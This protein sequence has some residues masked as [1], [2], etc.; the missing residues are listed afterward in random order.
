M[1]TIRSF[2]KVDDAF[3]PVSKY[4][5]EFPDPEFIDGAIEIEFDG[6]LMLSCKDWDYIDQLWGYLINGLFTIAEGKKFNTCL[7]EQVTELSFQPSNDLKQIK[8]EVMSSEYHKV[9]INF[10]EFVRVMIKEGKAFFKKMSE[11]LPEDKIHKD[12]YTKLLVLEQKL[13]HLL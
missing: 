8:F 5:G 6:E 12:E 11:L 3:I 10:G 1:F 9:I 4:F 13:A 2:F 7:P